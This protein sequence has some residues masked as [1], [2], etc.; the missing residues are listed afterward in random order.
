MNGNTFFSV[1]VPGAKPA[2]LLP[3]TW[4][5][6]KSIFPFQNDTVPA[7]TGDTFCVTVAVSVTTVLGL[8]TL[9][10]ELFEAHVVPAHTLRAVLDEIVS[11]ALETAINPVFAEYGYGVELSFTVTV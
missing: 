9:R 7:V 6:P 10:G 2:A 4:A 8:V 11:P 5:V 1:A 3:T